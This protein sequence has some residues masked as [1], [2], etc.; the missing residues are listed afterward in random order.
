[1]AAVVVANVMLS[2]PIGAVP[3]LQEPNFNIP[4]F[5][6][7]TLLIAVVAIPFTVA[8]TLLPAAAIIR[9]AERYHLRSKVFYGAAGALTNVTVL[10]TLII[11]LDWGKAQWGEALHL[12]SLE[13]LGQMFLTL[14]VPGLS[15]GLVYWRVAGRSAG[16]YRRKLVTDR[17]GKAA[18]RGV[19]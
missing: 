2:V 15:G 13:A 18:Y 1:M 3:A 19:A 5:F 14:V 8:L 4:L 17:I 12:P 9:Y 16:S 7:M 6:G 11:L 10:G